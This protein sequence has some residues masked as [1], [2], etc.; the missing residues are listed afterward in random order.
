M[1]PS[2]RQLFDIP[3]G[4]AYLN[5]AYMSP[6]MHSVAEA[7][8][9]G[10]ARK[11]H[12]WEIAVEDFFTQSEDLRSL[13]AKLFR[14]TLDDVA[15]VPS[16]SY[17]ISTA[18]ANL[19]VASGQS[20]MILA[21]QFPSN[22]YPWHRM[23]QDKNASLLTVPWPQD[24]NWT[25][26][27]LQHLQPGVAIAALPHTQWSSGGLLDLVAIA[28]ACRKNGTAL[29]VDLTQSLGAYPFDAQKVQPDFAVAA[30]YKWLLGP[31]SMGVMYVAPRWQD[32][33]PLEENWIQRANARKFSDLI[34]YTDQY[35]PGARRFDMGERSNLSLVPAATA[36]I[37]QILA[38]GVKEISDTIAVLTRRLADGA[39][40]L[41]FS[42]CPDSY[43][44]PHYMCLRREGPTSPKLLDRLAKEKI[45]VSLR[46]SSIRVT[47]H[48]YNTEQDVDRLL[49]ALRESA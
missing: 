13:A 27:V 41:G 28:E 36:A 5:C 11:S 19:P 44:A 1:I 48:L 18:A 34:N 4:V 23:A 29:V 42:V 38:W 20:I 25:A 31:Y 14:C 33:K 49:A 43:R 24:G 45:Y 8:K 40:A 10:F 47:P 35:E 16:A 30:T 6:L 15:L 21:E 17:G 26:A 2:Q 39:A 46:G 7:G 3:D 22:Y 37:G 12:P 32:G 9:T